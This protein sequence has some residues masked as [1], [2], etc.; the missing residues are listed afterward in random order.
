ML[1]TSVWMWAQWDTD[2]AEVIW[3]TGLDWLPGYF[4][5]LM[6]FSKM[7]NNPHEL[8]NKASCAFHLHIS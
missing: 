3:T 6:G 2:S 1:H 4:E 7:K 8:K 5:W